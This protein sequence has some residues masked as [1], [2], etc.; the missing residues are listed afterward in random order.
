MSPT[1][2]RPR[3]VSTLLIIAVVVASLL[4]GAV[5]WAIISTQGERE[6]LRS[7]AEA[8]IEGAVEYE[9]LTRDHVSGTVAY[10]Q[11][12]PVGGDH[13][14]AW[15]NCNYYDTIIPDENAV[16]SLEH[17]AV[18][19][20]HDESLSEDDLR[21]LEDLA[22]ENPYLMVSPYPGQDSPV[23]LSAWGVQ[24]SLDSLDDERLPVFL[25][26]Y[27]QGEQTPEPG[28]ACSNG[29]DF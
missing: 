26:K 11:S 7:R 3:G 18:W 16:H 22:G 29:L 1:T 14:P 24:L 19:I 21:T 15:A 12:P 4:V 2:R 17:G 6:D 27:L 25:T 5:A 28:A 8:P 20:T 13:N 9:D 10:E 23:V